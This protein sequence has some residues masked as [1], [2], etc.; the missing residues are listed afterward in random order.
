MI[1]M[2]VDAERWCTVICVRTATRIWR[3]QSV[4]SLAPC[5]NVTVWPVE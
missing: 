2:A 5:T 1:G 3:S 4:T